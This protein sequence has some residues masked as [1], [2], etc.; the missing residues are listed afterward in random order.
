MRLV[1]AKRSAKIA[2]KRAFRLPVFLL[3][4]KTAL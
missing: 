2:G 1:R 3:G 4:R